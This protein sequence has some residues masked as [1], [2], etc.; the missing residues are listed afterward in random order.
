MARIPQ[1][2]RE[3]VE[4]VYMFEKEH[5]MSF[6]DLQVHHLNHLPNEVELGGVLSCHWMVF[7]ERYMKKLKGFV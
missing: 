6:M 7:L 1:W 3:V 2:H 4:I 5:P